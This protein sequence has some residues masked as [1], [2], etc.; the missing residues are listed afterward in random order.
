[1]QYLWTKIL[2]WSTEKKWNYFDFNE[3]ETLFFAYFTEVFLN[4]KEALQF[5]AQIRDDAR[6]VGPD[7]GPNCWQRLSA[8]DKSRR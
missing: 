3:F 6:S 5:G 8:D 2:L 4:S 7:L 1:M